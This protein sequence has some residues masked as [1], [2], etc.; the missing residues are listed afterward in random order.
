MASKF[1]W[2]RELGKDDFR[3]SNKNA[4]MKSDPIPNADDNVEDTSVH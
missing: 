3:L 2:I 1:G 4:H